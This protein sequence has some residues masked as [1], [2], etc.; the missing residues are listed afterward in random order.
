VQ[1]ARPTSGW[2]AGEDIDDPY[3]FYI[4][5][6]GPAGDY[7][8]IVGWYLLADMSRL[9]VVDATGREVGDFYEIGIFS[10]P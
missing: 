6:N 3:R 7:R 5:P 8:V 2:R 1:G 9:P 10:L 4:A